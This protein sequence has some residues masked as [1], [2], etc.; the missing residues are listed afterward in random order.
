MITT[1]LYLDC[2]RAKPGIVAPLNVVLTKN[3][4]RSLIAIGISILPSQWDTVRQIVINHPQKLL[5]NTL[6]AE[7]KLEVDRILYRLLSEGELSGMKSCEIR[8]RVERELFPDK[9]QRLTFISRFDAYAATRS[10][11]T[12]RIYKFTRGRLEAFLG[13]DLSR[14]TFEQMN[15][16]WLK[17]F[18]AFLA[19]SSPSKN[20]RNIHFRNIRTVFNDALADEVI[21]CYPFR[22][23]KLTPVATRKRALPTAEL[24]RLMKLEGLPEHQQRYVDCFKLIFLLCGINIVDLCRLGKKSLTDGR[25]EY[26]RAKTHRLYSIKLEPEAEGLISKYAGND[27]LL[28]FHDGCKSYRHFY[29]R[30]C[31]TLREVG[32]KLGIGELTTYRARHSWAT[33]A[34]ALDIPKETIAAA[35][36]HGGST[37]TDIYIDFDR[38]KID[39]ANRMVID[40]VFGG[41]ASE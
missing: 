3:G 41:T 18:D 36:G 26:E 25:V 6:I 20:S 4:V 30:L 13:D 39:R 7:R 33:V 9:E 28:N 31:M 40:Y 29:T 12:Q 21:S 2:R 1:R 8:R 32:E 24:R 11:G 16:A 14:L 22:K 23:F 5:Y 15:V 38:A 35:L 19:K 27:W 37:V 17:Q 34:A 10:E